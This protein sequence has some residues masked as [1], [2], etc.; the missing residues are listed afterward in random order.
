[1]SRVASEASQERLK[2]VMEKIDEHPNN[3]YWIGFL[4]ELIDAI[5]ARLEAAEDEAEDRDL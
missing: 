4:R 1:M 2:R 5:K 3:A